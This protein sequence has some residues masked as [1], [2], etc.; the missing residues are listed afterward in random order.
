MPRSKWDGQQAKDADY[1][2]QTEL[3]GVKEDDNTGAFVQATMNN[4]DL[5]LRVGNV[6]NR[7]NDSNPVFFNPSGNDYIQVTSGSYEVRANI[8]YR[9]T[10]V[11]TPNTLI[12]L[13]SR[14]KSTGSG[15]FRVYDYGNAQE[16][17][18]RTFTNEAK[19]ILEYSLNATEIS[20]FPA[21]T[22]TIELQLKAN[23]CKVYLHAAGLYSI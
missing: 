19:T 7:A 10:N 15:Y 14:S 13:T 9:G 21:T 1:A 3:D 12:I 2:L 6:E 8:A 17:C 16:I 18:E 22:T 5:W 11:W 23:A 20:R 4:Y